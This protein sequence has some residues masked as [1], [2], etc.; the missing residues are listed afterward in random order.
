MLY[1]VTGFLKEGAEGRLADLQD[2]FNEHLAQPY[3]HLRIAG[4]LCDAGGRRKGFLAL[5][6]ADSMDEAEAYLHESPLYRAGLYD[7]SE[8]AE[9]EIQ[10]GAIAGI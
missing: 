3:R 6:E 5:V 1:A 2:A 4:T 8:V 9:Y 7:R 10:V